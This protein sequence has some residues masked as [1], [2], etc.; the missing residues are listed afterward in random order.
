MA[1]PPKITIGFLNGIQTKTGDVGND[2]FYSDETRR[3]YQ[4]WKCGW[5]SGT[6][7]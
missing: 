7:E 4:Y 3:K 6:E 1:P 5:S 2:N